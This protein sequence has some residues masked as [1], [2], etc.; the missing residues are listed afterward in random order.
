MGGLVA[1][2]CAKQIPDKIV[3]VVHGVMPALGAPLCYR[4]IACG[5]ESSAPGKSWDENISM[6]KF[7]EIAG[8]TTEKATPT[9]ATA[10]GPLELLPNQLYP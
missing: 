6:S 8:E 3:G 10:S 2:A 1:R 7:A 4:R 5:T 9:K